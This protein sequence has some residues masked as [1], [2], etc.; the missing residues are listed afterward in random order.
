M[1]LGFLFFFWMLPNVMKCDDNMNGFISDVISSFRLISPTII[2]H[3]D[4][5]E[6]CF[7]TPWVL[8]LQQDILKEG[9][10]ITH[11]FEFCFMREKLRNHCL[12]FYR[13]K[14]NMSFS[15][16]GQRVMMSKKLSF[17][18]QTQKRGPYS[19]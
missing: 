8:C 17:L 5:P 14:V 6:L 2:Y 1:K 11:N 18:L 12:D 3:G 4:A 16:F 10:E 15:Q 9:K 13:C 19:L 7:T